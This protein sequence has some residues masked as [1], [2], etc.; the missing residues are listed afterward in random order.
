VVAAGR[1]PSA[2]L[3]F[4]DSNGDG[5]GGGL[6]RPAAYF[7]SS[8][9]DLPA[10]TLS[11]PGSIFSNGARVWP[12]ASGD[13]AL[14]F[15][16]APAGGRSVLPVVEVSAAAGGLPVGFD[17]SGTS[18]DSTCADAQPAL[19]SSTPAKK[20]DFDQSYDQAQMKAHKDAV[21]LFEAYSKSGDNPELKSW[22][23]KTLPQLKE[24]LS[25]ASGRSMVEKNIERLS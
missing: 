10:P 1:D 9:E 17:A 14:V 19:V 22:A 2:P 15:G 16:A 6:C 20:M 3:S 5:E 11:M 25:M 23:A 8:P 18:R 7:L 13:G 24:H 4:Q 21:A 12:V